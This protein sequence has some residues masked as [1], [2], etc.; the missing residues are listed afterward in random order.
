[1]LW[2]SK[3]EPGPAPDAAQVAQLQ[4]QLAQAWGAAEEQAAL[5]VLRDSYKV[6]MLPDAKKLISGEL[7]GAKL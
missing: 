5:R 6:K 4:A 2:L 7:D 1:V 3:I